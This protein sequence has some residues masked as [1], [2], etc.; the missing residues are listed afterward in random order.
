MTVRL[1]SSL[2]A[3]FDALCSEFGMS[4]NTAMNV[5]A[6]AVVQRGRIPFEIQ[7]DRISVVA[8]GLQAY[9]SIRVL[10]EQGELPSLSLDEINKEIESVRK[11]R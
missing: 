10:A 11:R 9:K 5:F 1:D 7:S 2:K 6:R 8:E 3:E 4:A